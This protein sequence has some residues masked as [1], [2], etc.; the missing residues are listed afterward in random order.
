MKRVI[1]LFMAAGIVAVGQAALFDNFGGYA[2][3]KVQAPWTGIFAGTGNAVI[4]A[5]PS[6]N[7]YGSWWA[8]NNGAR[9][10]WRSLAGNSIV[11]ADTAT[12]VY[13]RVMTETSTNDGSF[14][15]SD[16]AVPTTWGDFEVQVALIN[17]GLNARNGGGVVP[18][19]MT[20]TV[21]AW[22]NVWMVIDN[23]TDTYDVYATSSG[24]ATGLA[25][26]ADNFVFRNSGA[27]LVANDLITFM[28]LANTR[29]AAEPFR[30]DDI[31]ITSGVN[32]TIP[33]PATLVLLSLG[34]LLLRRKNK[35]Y[36]TNLL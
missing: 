16:I 6:G 12:T 2:I 19:N 32:L 18:L 35:A 15:L 24:D 11:N 33:E 23:S 20:F 17:G 14:G 1:L 21:G 36:D 34:G 26:L 31:H 3:G 30:I 5:E 4:A 22:Y 10:M 27:G 7:Q 28:T 9:G 25:P 29:A 13:M 8:A